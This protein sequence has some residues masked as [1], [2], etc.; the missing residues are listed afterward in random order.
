MRRKFTRAIALTILALI[1]ASCAS[2]YRP[3]H[4]EPESAVF[5]GLLNAGAPPADDVRVLWVHGMCHHSTD[6]VLQRVADL[7][8]LGGVAA[9]LEGAI[10][11]P[12][13]PGQAGPLARV[14]RYALRGGAMRHEFHF[15]VW[16]DLTREAKRSLCY[17]SSRRDDVAE[18]CDGASDYPSAR[19][20][21]T[22]NDRLK[23]MIM[24]TCV[25]DALLYAGATGPAMRDRVAIAVCAALSGLPP[26]P[27]RGGNPLPPAACYDGDPSDWVPRAG[28]IAFVTE[29][30]G[31]KI[32]FD[33]LTASARPGAGRSPAAA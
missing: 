13:R 15:V 2:H 18:V 11:V 28:P 1:I 4:F 6:W 24:N 33:A 17:D 27:A 32:L 19:A 30:L 16:S 10:D 14:Y 20:R 25:S 3:P 21:G 23:S 12:A 7:E 9:T 29:S 26:Q 22:L 31:S 8:K 5:S